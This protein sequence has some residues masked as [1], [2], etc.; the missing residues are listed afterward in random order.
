MP[1]Q[2]ENHEPAA[3]QVT[4][5]ALKQ[6]GRVRKSEIRYRRLFEAARDGILILNPVTRKI[7]DVNPFMVELLG[8]QREEFLGKELWEIGLLKDEQASRDAF[9]ELEEKGFIRYEDLPLLAKTGKRREVEFVSNVYEEDDRIVIQCNIRDITERKRA[10]KKVI[11]WKNRYELII[12][13]SGQLVYDYDVFTGTIVWGGDL[14]RIL[15]MSEEQM[16]GGIRQWVSM[17]HPDDQA[18]AL[19]LMEISQQ[20]NSVYDVEYRFRHNDGSYRWM[21]DRGY[22]LESGTGKGTRLIGMMRDI[23]NR[24]LAEEVTTLLAQTVKSVKDLISITHLDD[25]ILFANDAFLITYGY[26]LQELLGKNISIIR[27]SYIA[28]NI[29]EEVFRQTQLDGWHGELIN[30]R[31]DGSEFP[32]ELW[33]S[34][35]SDGSGKP[36][37]TVGVARDITQRKRE[38]K[39][40]RSSRGQLRELATRLQTIREEE[41]TRIAREIHDELGQTLTGLQIDLLWLKKPTSRKPILVKKKLTTMSQRI[42]NAIETV[43]KIATQLRPGVLEL[44]LPAAIDWQTR[45]FQTRTGIEC[46]VVN[47]VNDNEVNELQSINIFRIFQE[48]LTNVARHAHATKI[49]IVLKIENNFLLLD[50]LDNGEGIQSDELRQTKSL[51]ILGMRERAELLGGDFD[52][53]GTAGKGTAVHV[54]IPLT[55]RHQKGI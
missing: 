14:Q 54:K 48:I 24:K 28:Q 2:S 52:I 33:T 31:K 27:P 25:T 37:A 41:G 34:T 5:V 9:R 38:E 49:S 11:D 46:T 39:E 12:A 23:G 7:T 1:I 30:R 35:V 20:S 45:E 19:R 26:T 36:I 21:H 15:G 10:E 53:L 44:G 51:G 29:G 47:I 16:D 17:I 40:L 55:E 13:A 32:I 18:E 3:E 43:R 8:Y 6:K 22:Y 50:V 4:D 42:D